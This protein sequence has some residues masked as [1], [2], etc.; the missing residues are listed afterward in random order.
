MLFLLALLNSLALDYVTR[1]KVTSHVSIYYAYQLPIPRLTAGDPCFD[2]IVPR[3]A[4]L[5]CT[6][7]VF[8]DLWRD[9]MGAPWDAG[10]AT[11]DPAERQRLRDEIDALVAHL[12]GLTRDEFA[13]ILGA[14]PLVFPDDAAGKQKKAGL[15][16]TYDRMR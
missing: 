7:P 1:S 3:A 5:T 2:A 14:F 10:Q 9:V 13:H 6:A 16:A 12:Y 8:A 4:R 15:L 11:T